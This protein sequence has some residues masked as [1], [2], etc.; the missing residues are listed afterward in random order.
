MQGFNRHPAV[1]TYDFGLQHWISPID[2]TATLDSCIICELNILGL[3]HIPHNHLFRDKVGSV[4]DHLVSFLNMRQFCAIT[5]FT[6]FHL[7]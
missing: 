5:V 1:D 6:L 3:N 4:K 7:L 2:S